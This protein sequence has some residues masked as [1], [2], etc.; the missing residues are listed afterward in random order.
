MRTTINIDPALQV[1]KNHLK[2]KISWKIAK[3]AARDWDCFV[4]LKIGDKQIKAPVK[5][6]SELRNMHLAQLQGLKEKNSDFILFATNVAKPLREKLREN[7]INFV[8]GYGN[9]LINIGEIHISTEGLKGQKQ[10]E[11][12]KTF[13]ASNLKLIWFLLQKTEYLNKSYRDISGAAGVSLDTI[14]KTMKALNKQNYCI[15]L[16]KYEYKLINKKD[17]YEKW[18]MGFED[19][20]KPKLKIN[21]Y[22]FVDKKMKDNWQDIKLDSEKILW[23]GEPAAAKLTKYLIPE[24]FTVYTSLS[25]KDLLKKYRMVQDDKGDIEAYQLFFKSEEFQCQDIVPPLVI[26]A[27]LLISGDERNIETAKRIF[28]EYLANTIQ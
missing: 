26:Y 14:S 25:D 13:R 15:S 8:D 22:R 5:K 9:A 6:K 12:T 20:L 16:N 28:D 11:N 7:E 4:H 2:L 3:S 19:I 1:L 18:L 27:D 24:I 21:T 17:L 23:G 10:V